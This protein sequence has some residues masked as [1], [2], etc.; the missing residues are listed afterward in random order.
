MNHKL[1]LRFLVKLLNKQINMGF[2]K[3]MKMHINMHT[4]EKVYMC[5]LPEDCLKRYNSGGGLRILNLHLKLQ[6][7]GYTVDK[8]W[9]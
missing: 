8:L 6:W 7:G 1:V 5:D 9:N 2:F 3:N 4:L